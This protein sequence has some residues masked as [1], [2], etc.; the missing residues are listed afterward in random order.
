[1]LA[2]KQ[3]ISEGLNQRQDS[4]RMLRALRELAFPWEDSSMFVPNT[5]WL[6]LKS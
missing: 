4:E 6:A 2:W 1:M 5:K 3:E